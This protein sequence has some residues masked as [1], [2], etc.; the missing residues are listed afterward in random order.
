MAVVAT[1]DGGGGG[2]YTS[3]LDFQTNYPGGSGDVRV[4]DEA[5]IPDYAANVHDI[6]ARHGGEYL[7]RSGVITTLEGDE[8]EST[9]IALIKFPTAEALLNFVNSPDY[10]PYAKARRDGSISNFRMIDDSDLAGSIPYLP[11]G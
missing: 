4:T 10:A 11:A 9:L 5:W 1:I 2:D 7:S 3:F 6:V 8:N